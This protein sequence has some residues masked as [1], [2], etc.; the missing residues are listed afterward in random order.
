MRMPTHACCPKR[1]CRRRRSRLPRCV[2]SC[3]APGCAAVKAREK[4]VC[5]RAWCGGAAAAKAR[6]KGV[7]A[8]VWRRGA[9]HSRHGTSVCVLVHGAGVPQSCRRA[10][11]CGVPQ[12][13]PTSMRGHGKRLCG[14]LI[15]EITLSPH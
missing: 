11:P 6:E 15:S 8:R 1:T 3:V 13:R 7:C 10:A 2:C 5:A 9:Q 4:G 12:S 14:R